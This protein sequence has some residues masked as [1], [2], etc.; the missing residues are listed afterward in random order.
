MIGYGA[1]APIPLN[2][3]KEPLSKRMETTTCVNPRYKVV[4]EIVK[5]EGLKDM[6]AKINQWITTKQLVKVETQPMFD[7]SIFFKIIQLKQE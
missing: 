6:Q 5:P 7:G 3:M 2:R 4:M 1:L